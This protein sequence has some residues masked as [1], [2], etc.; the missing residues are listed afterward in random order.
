MEN[1]N[2]QEL[3]DA[4]LT[5]IQVTGANIT[6]ENRMFLNISDETI[7]NCKKFYRKYVNLVTKQE[8]C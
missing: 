8:R 6:K 4:V 5:Y 2:K 7:N 3:Y 1:I